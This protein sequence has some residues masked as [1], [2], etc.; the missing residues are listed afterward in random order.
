L[1]PFAPPKLN[2]DDQLQ[3]HLRFDNLVDLEVFFNVQ[4]HDNSWIEALSTGSSIVV[5]I[6]KPMSLSSAMMVVLAAYVLYLV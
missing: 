6:Q 2:I 1:R 5:M 4:G 3:N